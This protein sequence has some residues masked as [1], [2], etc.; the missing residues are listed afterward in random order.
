MHTHAHIHTHTCTHMHTYIHTHTLTHTHTHIHTH[1]YPHTHTYIPHQSIVHICFLFLSRILIFV[2]F[3]SRKISA[4]KKALE[5]NLF[6]LHP[7]LRPALLEVHNQCVGNME[8]LLMAAIDLGTTYTLEEFKTCH[9]A[10]MALVRP[11][12]SA[13]SPHLF[14]RGHFQSMFAFVWGECV[15]YCIVVHTGRSLLVHIDL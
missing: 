2:S 11:L 10:K 8:T 7:K 5:K 4:C 6:I 9:M 12:R 3:C 15:S 14:Q 1:T 13:P